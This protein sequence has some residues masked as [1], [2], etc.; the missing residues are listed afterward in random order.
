MGIYSINQENIGKEL[1][2]LHLADSVEK[3]AREQ[4][5]QRLA[6]V[7][8]DSEKYK[9]QL[10]LAIISAAVVFVFELFIGPITKALGW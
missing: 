10:R 3:Q 2:A 1:A 8:D 5:E 6:E 4:F 7:K 9:K